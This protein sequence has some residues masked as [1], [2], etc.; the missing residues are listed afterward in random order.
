M[1][2]EVWK[3]IPGYSRYSVSSL[4]NVRRDVPIYRTPAGLCKRSF[5]Q[6]YPQVAITSDDGR[7]VTTHVH[8]LLMLAFVGPC[9][10]GMLVRHR[11]G[12][13]SNS[14]LS[15]LRYGTPTENVHDAIEHGTQV[16]GEGVSQHVLTEEEVVGIVEKLESG[17]TYKEIARDLPVTNHCIYRIA[18]GFT[19]KHITGGI[20]RRNGYKFNHR[21][22][23]AS[24]KNRQELKAEALAKVVKLDDGA[25]MVRGGF[26]VWEAA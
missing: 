4:G 21:G 2:D 10:A 17:A 25:D 23:A 26:R 18:A 11:D 19:W 7:H 3:T 9:P 6:G 12:D 16:K 20:D 8:R 14:V 15:N 1:S 24:K 13:S 22:A 5:K